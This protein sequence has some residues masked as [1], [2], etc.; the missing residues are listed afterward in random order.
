MTIPTYLF[1]TLLVY[2]FASAVLALTFA[3]GHWQPK[4]TN[5]LPSLAITS[6]FTIALALTRWN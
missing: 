6:A 1:W 4:N 5:W 2:F 3:L